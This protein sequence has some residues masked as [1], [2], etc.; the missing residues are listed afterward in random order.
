MIEAS[1]RVGLGPRLPVLAVSDGIEA[2]LGYPAADFL[3]GRVSLGERIHAHD[4]DLA[5]TLFAPEAG[6]AAGAV[7]L[8]LR[9]ANGRIRC[10]RAEYR[11]S[12][13]AGME[14][15]R[16]ELLL[17]DAKGLPRTLDAAASCLS[18]RAMLESTDD[19]IYF[20]DRNHVF[21]G[22]SQSLVSICSPAEHWT[23]LLGQTDYDVF[24][25]EYADIYYRLEKQVFA[26]L[27]VAREIQKTLSRD[28]KPGWVDNRK[29]PIRDARGEIIGLFGIARDITQQIETELAERAARRALRLLSDC[30]L[31]LA[32]SDSE[33]GLL[34]DICRIAVESGGYR[35]A[36]IGYAE[37]DEAKTVR[38]VGEWGFDEGYLSGIKVSWDAASGYG[39]GP[40]G[41]AIR[42]GAVQVNQDYLNDPR[43]APWRESALRRGYQSSIALPLL[44]QETGTFGALMI[45]A[46]EPD[47][48][49]PEEVRLLSELA[50]NLAFGI[51]H[52]RDRQRR[53]AAEAANRS[54][55]DFLANMSH[56]IRT[57]LNAIVG[58][59]YLIQRDGVTP[60]QAARLDK[61]N[62]AGQHL[63]EIIN[64]ILDLSKIEAGKFTLEAVPVNIDAILA[65]VASMVTERAHAKHLELRVEPP[66]TPGPLLGDPTRLQQAL[67]NYAINAVKFTDA[68]AVSLRALVLDRTE[69]SALLR[70]EVEDSGIGIEPEALPRLFTAFEQADNSTTRKYGGTG[71]G[72]AITRKLAE[73]M[74]GTAGAHS[75]PGR[76]ST[77]WFTARLALAAAH[78][79]ADAGPAQSSHAAADT[80]KASRLLLVEDE[81]INREIVVE[82]LKDSVGAIDVAEDGV[83][84]VEMAGRTRY[85]LILMDMQMPRMDG[86]EA[87]R[88]IRAL[89]NG[90]AVPIVAMTA[91]AFNEDRV[92]C[93]EAGMNDFLS[94]PAY[95]DTLHEMLLKWL[96]ARP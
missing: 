25:E 85:D 64:T 74:G 83:Q 96:A 13:R 77:F 58:L 28:G 86:L 95:P 16:M 57:P 70:F 55:S 37:H 22:A 41:N 26:G 65:N 19:Y 5:E 49:S 2:L 35:M 45:Y 81:V 24:P 33:A 88:R 62:V 50:A 82:L 38:P 73:L 3:A 10:V 12:A 31:V 8:R 54:K 72:L 59:S 89:P 32:H 56:E 39:Q 6:E 91:N 52:L 9:Q 11:K 4:R 71:L 27:P 90:A 67:L 87:T 46:S 7:S 18:Q 17:Q 44:S 94:K 15:G 51:E 68:G 21:T 63:L 80:L 69:T 84:A 53:F 20:K 61:I 36:W 92:R 47:A 60:E 93:L 79:A 40:T 23:D 14:A 75:T 66:D 29:Y 42:S 43:M 34:N 48:F 30:N 1:M 76:G 78:G